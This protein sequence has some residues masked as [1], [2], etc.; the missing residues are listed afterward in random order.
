MQLSNDIITGTVKYSEYIDHLQNALSEIKTLLVQDSFFW[1]KFD[2][3][4]RGNSLF[5]VWK[6]ESR[7]M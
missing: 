6:Q 5:T 4:Q 1:R 7:V 3:W 2:N